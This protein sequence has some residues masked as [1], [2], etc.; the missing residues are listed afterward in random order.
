[1]VY[2]E[3][4]YTFETP[5]PQ[6][7]TIQ[8]TT[9]QPT[10]G[11]EVSMVSANI[12]FVAY[13]NELPVNDFRYLG[14]TATLELNWDDPWYSHFQ[15]RN[16]RRQNA[17]PILAYLYVEPFEVRKE[18]IVRPKDLQK[19]V[20]LG[21]SDSNSIPIDQQPQLKQRVASFLSEKN[22]VTIDGQVATGQLDRI[23]FV[24]R[25]LR[26][27][28]IVDPPEELHATSATLGVIFIYPIESLPQEVTMRW[29]LFDDAY[30]QVPGA[31][32]DEAGPMP[33]T[34]TPEDPVLHWK[35][36]LRNPTVPTFA[37]IAP[38]PQPTRLAIPM[39]TLTCALALIPLAAAVVSSYKR[40]GAVSSRSSLVCLAVMLIGVMALPYARVTFASPFAT[41]AQLTDEQAR[42]ILQ[43]LLHNV[44]RSFDRRNTSVIYDQLSRSI[45]GDLLEQVYLD[46]RKSIEVE[47]QGGLQI[48]VSE[49]AIE[50]LQSVSASTAAYTYRCRWRVAG[51]VGHW[52]HIHSRENEVTAQITIAT[53]DDSWKIVALQLIHEPLPPS[54]AST[55]GSSIPAP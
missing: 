6:K 51:A 10:T 38:P 29:E 55:D 2:A 4:I 53:V 43:G 24:R 5:R 25:S 52:G 16:L 12:G 20:D 28:G 15:N 48:K 41:R 42:E 45:A 49:V 27:T 1:V 46:T 39:V 40:S 13:H 23:H 8:P 3:L 44:Y 47:N 35:N 21:L 18:I 54:S 19:F 34:L 36:F 50:D 32:T 14:T 33:A 7:L 30:P 37:T 9:G 31:A 22:P 17:A 26:R 11:N